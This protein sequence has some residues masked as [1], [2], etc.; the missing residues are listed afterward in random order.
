MWEKSVWII[1]SIVMLLI[2][3]SLF[4]HFQTIK[5]KKEI[6]MQSI[7]SKQSNVLEPEEVQDDDIVAKSGPVTRLP[8]EDDEI[9]KEAIEKNNLFGPI[10]AYRTV[11]KDPLPGEEENVHLAARLLCGTIVA[12]GEIFSQ[13][14]SIGPYTIERGFQKGPTYAG[15][16]LI[17][18]IGGGVC[19]IASTLYNVTVMS[20]LKIIERHAHSMP[21][22][23]VPYG[24]DATVAYGVKDFKFQN[25]TDDA[26]LIWSKGIE[27]IL[28]I[29]FYGRK[30]PPYIQWHHREL[31]KTPASR[32]YET[33]TQ[34]PKGTEKV[35]HEGMDGGIIESWITIEY[36]DGTIE[37]KRL[38]RS[39]YNPMPHIIER[40]Q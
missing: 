30:K 31:K 16:K 6:K 35:I 21:V 5:Y 20:N 33:N 19:K 28:Y 7:R 26:I 3:G 22:P 10:A 39:Y 25:N 36:D 1:L 15:P 14:S 11:L 34:L 24:Q 38:G 12:P 2:A 27:N 4:Q 32:V 37:V 29:A 18:T 9:F 17:T 23:Y 8:W 40:N 13:N